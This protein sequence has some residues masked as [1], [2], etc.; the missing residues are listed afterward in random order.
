M[1]AD[2]AIVDEELWSGVESL[3]D[4]YVHIRAEDYVV[5]LYTSDSYESAA[6]VSVALESRNIPVARVWMAPLRDETLIDRLAPA[7]PAPSEIEGRL[8]LLSLER[9]T[10][11]HTRTLSLALSKYKPDRRVVFRAISA[12][13]SLFHDALHV[14]P[15]ELSARNTSILERCLG[16]HEL[17]I[18]TRGGTDLAVTI[19]GDRYRWVSNRGMARP[20][21]T[22]ILPAGEVATFPASI[23][24]QFV[25]DFAFNLNAIT[26]RD[27]RLE[28]HPVHVSIED[29]RAVRC[30]CDDAQT[31]R[32]L[33]ECFGTHCAYYVG[34]LGFGTNSSVG[35][36][37]PLNSHIN[38]RRPGVHLGFGQHNQDPGVVGYQ[39][40]IHLDLIARGGLLWIDDEPEPLDLEN[41]SPS[42]AKH[43]RSTLDEDVFSP[44]IDDL[45]VDDCCGILT[46]DGLKLFSPARG[47]T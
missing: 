37:I 14:S 43:P 28:R 8:V 33:D 35:E 44:E 34:E 10:M 1:E 16:T 31:Q 42:A 39:C 40:A 11:S 5:L 30:E 9:D 12:G 41:V 27:A 19:D 4:K 17:R 2:A 46:D 6:W 18:T 38:E 45:D 23:S 25:G 20:G 36:A 24:G 21:S 32:F 7:L 13:P 3:L 15:E 22:V 26:D 47:P 29:G